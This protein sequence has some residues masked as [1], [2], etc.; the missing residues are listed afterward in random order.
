VPDVDGGRSR[1]VQREQ[2]VVGGHVFGEPSGFGGAAHPPRQR[3]LGASL[4]AALF[5]QFVGDGEVDA[6]YRIARG[7]SSIQESAVREPVTFGEDQRR[8]LTGNERRRQW[9]DVQA[10][11]VGA[12]EGLPAAG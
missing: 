4:R 5:Q 10:E 11:G 8:R 7:G 6:G 1:A 2:V 12:G 9:G 3:L